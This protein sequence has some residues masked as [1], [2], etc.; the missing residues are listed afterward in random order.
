MAEVN[1]NAE[2]NQL[3]NGATARG[4]MGEGSGEKSAGAQRLGEWS[5]AAS[6]AY[7]RASGVMSE[8]AGKLRLRSHDA[9]RTAEA[10]ITRKPVAA[11]GIALGIG[12]L[13]GLG[14]TSMIRRR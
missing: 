6:D 8:R 9:L 14:A 3:G 1:G 4:S 10:S 13:F 2:E 12:L 5:R 11:M 7:H